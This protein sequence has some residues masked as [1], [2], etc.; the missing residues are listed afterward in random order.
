MSS[1]FTTISGSTRSLHMQVARTI[2]RSILSGDLAQGSTI[3]NEI[4]LC[5]QFGI[6]R[7]ALREA[8][9]LLSSKGLLR[10]KPKIGTTVIE[11]NNWNFLDPQL[12]EWMDGLEN[13]KVFYQQFLGLRKAIE[14]EACALAAKN[15]SAEQRI[16]LSD[17]FQIMEEIAKD[18]DHDRW[19]E[20]DMH[21]HRL[22][23]LSTGN[24]F[25]IP[26]GN[27][28]A[29]IF[30]SFITYSSKDGGVCIKEHRAIYKAIMAG[31]EEQ[32]LEAS[33][34]LLIAEKHRLPV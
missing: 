24:D 14:P 33:R 30:M 6:S 26:F 5:K 3:P 31:K 20:A 7:T 19:A 11:K 17:T 34:S 27:V 28:L 2:A 8:V 23:F 12:L 16:E 4:T 1:V 9:K 18:F 22:I 13:S 15:A 10:S 32:A 29:T 25:Y 21:F